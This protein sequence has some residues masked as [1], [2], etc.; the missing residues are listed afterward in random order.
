MPMYGRLITVSLRTKIIM[1]NSLES[2]YKKRIEDAFLFLLET[3]HLYQNVVVDLATNLPPPKKDIATP[4]RITDYERWNLYHQN[5]WLIIDPLISISDQSM[6]FNLPTNI[7]F[8]PRDIKSFCSTCNHIEPFNYVTGHDFLALGKA[9]NQVT[10]HQ[11]MVLQT[12]IV[13]YVCQSCKGVPEVF[14]VRR[15]GAKLILSGRA[16]IEHIDIPN[17]VPKSVAKYYSGAVVAHQSGHT[18]AGNFFLRTIIEQFAISKSVTPKDAEDAIN[19]YMEGLP[20]DFKDRFPSF[21]DIYGTLSNDI[22]KAAGSVDVCEDSL[23]KILKHF[24]ARKTYEL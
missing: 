24:E 23:K 21:R 1:E 15:E 9:I 18:L 6:F 19:Q 11:S 16:P 20:G 7:S 22:H 13:S 5:N 8:R 3:K 4:R 14:V 12:F 17:N 10:Q 2:E